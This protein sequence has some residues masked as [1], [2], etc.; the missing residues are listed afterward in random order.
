MTCSDVR[1]T[2][3]D[4]W[5]R[6]G[7]REVVV[8][9]GHVRRRSP[10]PAERGELTLHVRIDERSAASSPWS[11]AGDDAAVAIVVTSGTAAAELHARLRGDQA[12]VPCS[13]SR[14]PTARTAR[15]GRSPD[16]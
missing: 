11:C 15:S 12:N 1:A 7:L 8:D 16:N 3:F 2:L 5:I 4:E 10:S 13:C 14:G 9:R 6:S